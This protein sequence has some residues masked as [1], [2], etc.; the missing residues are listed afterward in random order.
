MKAKHQCLGTFCF[1]SSQ[2]FK[3]GLLRA[4]LLTKSLTIRLFITLFHY[5][6]KRDKIN[7]IR[8]R[9]GQV[10]REQRQT[11]VRAVK[12]GIGKSDTD[13]R[14]NMAAAGLGWSKALA[15]AASQRI[16]QTPDLF[17]RLCLKRH[18]ACRICLF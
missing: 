6:Q 1:A 2:Q 9:R 18:P 10:R 3:D 4:S 12:H 13:V 11:P 5:N 8:I 15:K 17:C 7:T 14:M 16:R